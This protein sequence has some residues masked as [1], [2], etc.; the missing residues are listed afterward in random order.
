VKNLNAR[1]ANLQRKSSWNSKQ[2]W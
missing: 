2:V 1:S